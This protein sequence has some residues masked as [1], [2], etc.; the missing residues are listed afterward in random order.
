MIVFIEYNK[1]KQWDF[2]RPWGRWQSSWVSRRHVEAR[3]WFKLPKSIP[4]VKSLY[5]SD[6]VPSK[7]E[8]QKPTFHSS[9]L[10]THQPAWPTYGSHVNESSG[11]VFTPT[12]VNQSVSSLVG[13]SDEWNKFPEDLKDQET[14]HSW[15]RCALIMFK[16]RYFPTNCNNSNRTNVW[17][18]G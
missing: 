14:T 15:P 8:L 7:D 10:P 13:S 1:L 9:D 2:Q 18:T 6:D 4:F 17:V 3:V 12:L 5:D 16:S 11:E